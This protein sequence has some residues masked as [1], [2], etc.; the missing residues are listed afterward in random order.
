[1]ARVL[2]TSRL[3]MKSLNTSWRDLL[4]QAGH[5]VVMADVPEKQLYPT[6][7]QLIDLLRGITATVASSESYT[8]TVLES[9]PDLRV[10]SR[11]GVGYDAIDTAAAADHNVVAMIAAGS[12]DTTVAESAVTMILAMARELCDYVSNTARGDWTRGLMNEIRG[13]TIGVVG[14]GRIG[15]SVVRRLAGF[16]AVLIAAEPYP[17]QQFVAENGIELVELD[18]LFR[19]ADYVTLHVNTTPETANLVNERRL[20]LMKPT[21]Y[22][23]NTARGGLVDEDALYTALTQG[24]IAGAAL[25]VRAQEPPSDHRLAQLPNVIATPHVAG[26][27]TDCVVRMTEM[28]AQNIIDVLQGSWRREMVVNGLYSD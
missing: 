18:D 20:G 25:D 15:R 8:R 9:A 24:G 27:S 3:A 12:N 21:A 4:H 6:E 13:K 28:S 17:D 16:E 1:M 23:V 19:R 2:V 7:T 10:V 26:I 11:V 5:E 14:L 22:L